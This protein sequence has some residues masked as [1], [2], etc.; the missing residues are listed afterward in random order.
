[1][2][3]ETLELQ[4]TLCPIET[5]NVKKLKLKDLVSQK[6][7]FPAIG[8]EICIN[9]KDY[10][11]TSFTDCFVYLERNDGEMYCV[12]WD[13]YFDVLLKETKLRPAKDSMMLREE[14]RVERLRHNATRL[15]Q[16][17]AIAG[18]IGQIY[19]E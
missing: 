2:E 16:R 7:C 13:D 3:R 11:I 1:M 15:R 8:S 5:G 12:T 14:I 10:T 6:D 18:A 4:T 9:H 17:I 19:K